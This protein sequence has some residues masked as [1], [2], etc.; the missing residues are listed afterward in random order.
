MA[1]CIKHSPSSLHHPGNILFQTMFINSDVLVVPN[2]LG[3]LPYFESRVL[4]SQFY[5]STAVLQMSNGIQKLWH[6]ATLQWHN[7]TT[8]HS[9][10]Q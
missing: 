5:A 4:T 1:L 8:E 9:E 3:P 7:L 10:Y 2:I 6:Y